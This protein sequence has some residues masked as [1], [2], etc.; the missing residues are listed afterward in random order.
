MRT[1]VSVSIVWRSRRNRQ[2]LTRIAVTSPDGKT[3]L[4]LCRIDFV[5]RRLDQVKDKPR[6]S[7]SMRCRIIST[8]PESVAG[9]FSSVEGLSC[10]ACFTPPG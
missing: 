3:A 1:E 6:T 2:L 8:S 5:F 7:T 4:T 10:L 9:P